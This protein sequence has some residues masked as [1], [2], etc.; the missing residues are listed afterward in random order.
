MDE[1]SFINGVI[2]KIETDDRVP[3]PLC[4]DTG[5]VVKSV[6]GRITR[7]WTLEGLHRHLAGSHNVLKC[8]AIEAARH[9]K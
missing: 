9:L 2:G 6:T 4:G 8:K 7:G 1:E 5:P 3:C